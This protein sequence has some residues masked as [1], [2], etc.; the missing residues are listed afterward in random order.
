M[1]EPLS[2][3]DHTLFHAL[4]RANI[5]GFAFLPIIIF[6]F[7]LQIYTASTPFEMLH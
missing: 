3:T 7:V 4:T 6:Q 2:G 1:Y 5:D